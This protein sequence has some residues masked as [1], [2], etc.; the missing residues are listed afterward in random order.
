M[1][2]EAIAKLQQLQNEMETVVEDELARFSDLQL[3]ELVDQHINFPLTVLA[4]SLAK[5][6]PQV[7]VIAGCMIRRVLLRRLEAREMEAV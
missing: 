4:A 6:S 2:A 5:G 1:N 3:F 7:A